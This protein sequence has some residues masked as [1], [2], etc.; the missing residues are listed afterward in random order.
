MKAY[1]CTRYGP[2]EVLQLQDM[3]KPIPQGGEILIKVMATTVT[4]ADW[5]V[6]SACLPRG[7]GLL[8]R[9]ALGFSRPLQ[10][11]LGSEL[12]G[13]VESV[14]KGVHH[15]KAGDAVLALPDTAVGCHAQY[16]CLPENAMVLPKPGNLSFE[17]AAALSFGGMTALDMLRKGRLVR[18]NKI[19]VVGASG[20]VGT[21]AVQPFRCRSHGCLQHGQRGAGEVIGCGAGH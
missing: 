21:A 7:F 10:P 8:G 2:P 14:G 15:F 17:Q 6:L 20:A 9:L 18:G 4:S 19:L 16:K 1:V 12:A 3:A 5:R 13:V 11:V